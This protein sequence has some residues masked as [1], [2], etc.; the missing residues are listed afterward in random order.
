MTRRP[1]AKTDD[2]DRGVWAVTGQAFPRPR[3]ASIVAALPPAWRRLGSRIKGRS[4][5]KN[6]RRHNPPACAVRTKLLQDL[7]AIGLGRDVCP[8]CW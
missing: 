5:L 4:R 7:L 3:L 2:I 1:I 8:C 6:A